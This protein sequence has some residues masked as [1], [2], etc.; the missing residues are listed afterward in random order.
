MKALVHGTLVDGTGADPVPDATVIV[1]DDGRIDGVGAG[2]VPPRGAEVIDVSDR[3]I[4]PG[5][6]DC[7]VHLFLQI[8]R[9]MRE[10]ALKPLTLHVFEAAERARATLDAGV[11]SVRDTGLTPRGFK[12][13]V[14]R[15]LI[16]SPN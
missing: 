12:M 4:M 9:S 1:D 16:P 15:G 7:H 6:I 3:T 14:L 10:Q 2:I 11:T 8:G 13:A 5:L